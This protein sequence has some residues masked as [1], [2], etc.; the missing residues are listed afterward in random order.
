ML[1][2]VELM[3]DSQA[4]MLLRITIL[5]AC[6]LLGCHVKPFESLFLCDLFGRIAWLVE[7]LFPD[8]ELNPG[9]SSERTE[10]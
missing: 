6:R 1:W 8:Q 2:D 10:A 4:L 9:S 3:Q 7:S 5:Q